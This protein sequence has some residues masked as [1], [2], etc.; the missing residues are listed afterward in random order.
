MCIIFQNE[1]PSGSKVTFALI[2]TGVIENICLSKSATQLAIAA[3]AA[4]SPEACAFLSGSCAVSAR[5]GVDYDDDDDNAAAACGGVTS[6]GK[7]HRMGGNP[8][9][10]TYV[11]QNIYLDVLTLLVFLLYRYISYFFANR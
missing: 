11:S 4:K 1:V 2:R 10:I 9:R 3:A 6:T 5:A 7:L 8:C